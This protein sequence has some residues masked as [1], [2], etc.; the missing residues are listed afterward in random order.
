[1]RPPAE[2]LSDGQL[3]RRF[4]GDADEGAFEELVRRHGGM[5]LGV[6][7]RVLGN[8]HDADDAFQAAF[9]VVVRKAGELTRRGTIGDWLYGVAYHTALKARAMA[10]KRRA[11]EALARPASCEPSAEPD[12]LPVLDEELS[13]L[14][15]KYR[16]PL[17]LC[18]L[19]GRP[20]RE[21]AQRL[22]IP[23][24][25]LSSRLTT[26]RRMLAD[27]LRRRGVA[28]GE[29]PALAAV[30]P[31]LVDATLRASQVTAGH[32]AAGV[33]PAAVAH[34]AMEVT[35]M[36]W[37]KK[38]LFGSTA[39][40]LLVA[41]SLAALPLLFARTE[42]PLPKK[43]P[44]PAA[45]APSPAPPEVPAWKKEFDKVYRLADGEVLKRVAPPFPE[46]RMEYYRKEMDWQF[47]HIPDAPTTFAFTWKGGKAVFRSMTTGSHGSD[48]EGV[49][50]ASVL[51][52]IGV[53]H[54]SF[55]GPQEL[56]E[57]RIPGDWVI[58]DGVPVEKQVARLGEILRKD[59]GVPVKLEFKDVE[60]EVAVAS[61]K[62]VSKPLKDRKANTIDIYAL[63]PVPNSGAGGGSGT[64]DEF[65]RALGSFTNVPV[66][67]EVQAGPK[68]RLS[69]YYHIRSPMLKDPANGIDT[70]AEDTDAKAVMPNVAAQTGLT[71]TFQK[72]K[73][74]MLAVEKD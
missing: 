73:V 17:V 50:L 16:L 68:A 61:G 72:R 52:T 22:G 54:Q 55:L 60:R 63:N 32:V 48:A 49:T 4:V 2:D 21:V 11:K 14:P 40:L 6:C 20:R 27:R 70:R 1:V 23:E 59:C 37:L 44:P 34:L 74:R 28:P 46:C 53:P 35:R 36:L 18:E 47:K 62:F 3:L 64:L 10:M 19:E 8:A 26:A 69:W 41:G 25:T 39:G 12:W 13:R 65:L 71:V 15:E 5:V 56:R 58:R 66:V 45:K 31:A 57:R 51:D 42:D 9:V 29:M 38:L 7:R 67:N 30:P 24:G 33:V 43:A